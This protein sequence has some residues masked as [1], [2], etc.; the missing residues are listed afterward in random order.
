MTVRGL[1]A[2]MNWGISG[3]IEGVSQNTRANFPSRCWGC[4]VHSSNVWF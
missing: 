2:R 3:I 4:T 1:N